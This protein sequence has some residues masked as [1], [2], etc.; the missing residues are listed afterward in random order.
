[1]NVKVEKQPKSQLKLTVTVDNKNVKEAYSEVLDTAVKETEIEGFRKGNAPREKVEAKLGPSKLYGDAINQLLQ[2]FYAQA[3]KENHIFPISNPKVE[4]KEF[5]L[6]K[7]F[8]FEAEV[9]TKPDIKLKD[10]KKALKKYYE[11]KDAEIKKENA[12]KLKDGEE[13]THD[14]A[15]V[16]TNEIVEV[17][18]E[19]ATLEVPD[20]LVEEETNRLVARMVDQI[21][22]AGMKVED[23]LKAQGTDMEALKEN[24]SKIAELN[25]K[26]ELVLNELIQQEKI[27]VPDSEVDQAIAEVQD[28]KAREQLNTPVQ[29]VYIRTILEKNKLLASLIKETEGEHHHE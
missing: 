11:K 18:I 13:I 23:Y 7:D 24:Y 25:V 5:D 22:S 12:K 15:H 4:V 29:R 20:I 26:G 19:N 9:A 10:Y 27:D 21:I 2:K 6:E 3:V 14:H 1:M 28:E 8:E 17:L 16:H